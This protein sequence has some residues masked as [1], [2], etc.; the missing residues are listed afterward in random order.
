[1]DVSGGAPGGIRTDEK[2]LGGTEEGAGESE[3]E[4]VN[5]G[6]GLARQRFAPGVPYL[7]CT[8]T[9]TTAHWSHL[10]PVFLPWPHGQVAAYDAR[11]SGNLRNGREDDVS[12]WLRIPPGQARDID[13]YVSFAGLREPRGRLLAPAERTRGSRDRGLPDSRRAH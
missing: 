11:L 8:V 7:P 9:A 1:V 2:V 4:V 10:Q 3:S 13:E 6:I 12:I 5:Q